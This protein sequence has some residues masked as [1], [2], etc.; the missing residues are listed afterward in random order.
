MSAIFNTSYLPS[1]EY[2]QCLGEQ[3]SFLID[4]NDRWKKKTVRNRC[5]I[6][7][8]NGVQCLSV[9]VS[10]QQNTSLIQDVK[11]DYSQQWIRV[12]KGALEAA[13]NTA[14]YFEFIKDDVWA[15]YHQKPTYLIDLNNLFLNLLIKK[16]K[17]KS[18]VVS[19]NYAEPILHDFRILSDQHN[20]LPSLRLMETFH[21]YHQVFSYKHPFIP[22]LSGLDYLVNNGAV[23]NGW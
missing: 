6:L 1:I 18:V 22:N 21:T 12:H 13:Y 11:I 16:L 5:F 23:N 14:P 8:P 9:P 3:N 2:L 19:D 17:L 20:H 10:A 4:L 7:S 15:I